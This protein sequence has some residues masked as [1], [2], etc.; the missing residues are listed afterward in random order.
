MVHILITPKNKPQDNMKTEPGK[1]VTIAVSAELISDWFQRRASVSLL[2]NIWIRP[3]LCCIRDKEK[4]IQS[5]SV[6][7]GREIINKNHDMTCR[8][9]A[10]LRTRYRRR[11]NWYTSDWR[12]SP[13]TLQ[14][15]WHVGQD[16][17][18]NVANRASVIKYTELRYFLF[19]GSLLR[20]S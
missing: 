13:Q 3:P 19:F 1:T 20:D 7:R 11:W 4:L 16:T 17:E 10:C 12:R 14:P 8:W 5:D 2:S 9:S 6:V 15:A 18:G